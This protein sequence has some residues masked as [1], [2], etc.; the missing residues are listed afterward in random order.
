MEL[1][2][3]ARFPHDGTTTEQMQRTARLFQAV[4]ELRGISAS[5]EVTG[6]QYVCN[7]ETV[8]TSIHGAFAWLDRQPGVKP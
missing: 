6:G 4:A 8:G 7:G 1:S 2:E 3:A 5:I